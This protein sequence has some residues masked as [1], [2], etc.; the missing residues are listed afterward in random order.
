MVKC[1]NVITRITP[2]RHHPDGGMGKPV[3]DKWEDRCLYRFPT[4]RGVQMKGEST[5]SLCVDFAYFG[6]KGGVWEPISE[7][8]F[9]ERCE[10]SEEDTKRERGEGEREM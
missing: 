4:V 10:G 8:G 5:C 7:G 9:R 1:V 3:S 6:R 2:H